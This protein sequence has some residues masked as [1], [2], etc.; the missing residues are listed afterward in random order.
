MGHTTLAVTC[1]G[2]VVVFETDLL[3]VWRASLLGL[4][5]AFA[6]VLALASLLL[7]LPAFALSLPAFSEIP[8]SSR[9]PIVTLVP[10]VA[11]VVLA[12]TFV[13]HRELL[14]EVPSTNFS[15]FNYLD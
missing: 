9:A 3:A 8:L 15:V 5:F 6:S 2:G 13:T 7:A 11:R 4:A 1:S 14:D 10:I 12:G